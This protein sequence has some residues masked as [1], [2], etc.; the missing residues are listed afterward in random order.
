MKEEHRNFKEITV[1]KE[2]E[3]EETLKKAEVF[4]IGISMSTYERSSESGAR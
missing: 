1:K 2:E 4:H 3:V